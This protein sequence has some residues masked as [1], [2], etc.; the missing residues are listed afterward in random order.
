MHLIAAWLALWQI[1]GPNPDYATYPDVTYKQADGVALT[2]DLFVPRDSTGPIP[3][4]VFVHGGVWTWGSKR[5]YVDFAG[6]LA[7][8]GVAAVLVDFRKAQGNGFLEP[9]TDIKDALRWT[10]AHA[11]EYGLDPDRIGLF[12][13]SSGGHLA[14]LAAFAGN[15][16]GLGDDPEGESSAVQACFLLYGLYD[17]ET[18]TEVGKPW[19]AIIRFYMGGTVDELPDEYALYSPLAHIDGSEPPTYFM[20][21]TKDAMVPLAQPEACRDAL[22]AAGVPVTL[23]PVDGLGHGFARVRRSTR[24]MVYDTL[25]A[26]MRE[27]L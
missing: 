22:D 24:P 26:F 18:A 19:E 15:G 11:G 27:T 2:V 25:L 23:Q 16:E 17:L 14:S 3:V 20:H 8:D 4:V 7:G 5:D 6:R 13:S 21:G 1:M 9:V 12:G 10:R